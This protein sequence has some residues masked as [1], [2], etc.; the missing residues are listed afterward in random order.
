VA[1]FINTF[2]VTK[3]GDIVFLRY[4]NEGVKWYNLYELPLIEYI[5]S[6]E[7]KDPTLY[8]KIRFGFVR[9]GE[10]TGDIETEYINGG[11]AYIFPSTGIIFDD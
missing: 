4:S 3:K 9:V 6:L 7:D 10:E 2:E 1:E 8:N 11:Y 5:N